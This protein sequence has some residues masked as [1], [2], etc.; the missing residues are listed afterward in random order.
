MWS[1][2]WE[3][4]QDLLPVVQIDFDSILRRNTNN[5]N[6]LTKLAEDFYASLG[7]PKMSE[8]FWRYSQVTKKSNDS[9][10]HGTAANM[11]NGDDF[12]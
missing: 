12:R 11:F 6:D 3:N 8:K 10:C 1:Q 9:S 2:S 5:I 4:I 7:F